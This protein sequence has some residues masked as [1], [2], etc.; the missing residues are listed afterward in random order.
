M[1]EVHTMVM[2]AHFGG[3]E[4]KTPDTTLL[5]KQWWGEGSGHSEVSN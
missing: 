4:R 3:G 2:H 1:Q 5:T